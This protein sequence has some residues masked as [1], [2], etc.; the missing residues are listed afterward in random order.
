MA[1]ALQNLSQYDE[2]TIPSGEPFTFGI[3]VSEWNSQ[4]THAL[5][6]A[7]YQ[8]LLKHG[9]REDH[10]C[11]I[12]VPGAFELPT[13]AKLL[14]GKGRMDAVICIGCVIKGETNHDQYISQ[15]VATG[16]MGL[17][18]ATGIP[19]IFGVL[20]PNN[21]QQAR[22]RSGG[23]HGNKGVEAAVSALR[24]AALRSEIQRPAK[25]VGFQRTQD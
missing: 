8:T 1:S 3:A 14:M 7:C 15:S 10:I 23:R 20:T 6:S 11:T 4:I 12:Q 18:V 13:G 22:D 5:F 17:A 16:L 19:C 21:E 24:M 2:G 9:A 25:T